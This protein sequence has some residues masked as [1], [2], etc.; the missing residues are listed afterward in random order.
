MPLTAKDLYAIL[1][2]TQIGVLIMDCRSSNDFNKSHITHPHC[3][4][5]PGEIIGKG[6]VN[7]YI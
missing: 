3:V 4:N 7:L 6:Y 5:I 2:D 1:Q